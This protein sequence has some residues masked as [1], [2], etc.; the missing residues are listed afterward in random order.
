MKYVSKCFA[1]FF[2]A[3]FASVACSSN[4]AD[5]TA[6]A[7]VSS[8]V[9][10]ATDAP[11]AEDP[12]VKSR[13]FQVKVPTGVQPGQAL[14]LVVL[15]HGYSADASLQD[16]Y[17]KL[18]QAGEAKKFLVALPNGTFDSNGK[19]FW[20]ATDAC[21][22]FGAQVDDV[23]YLTAVINDVKRRFTVDPKRVFLVGHSNGGFMSHRMACERS[24]MIAG[25][26]TLAGVN[27][28]DESK[29]TPT[30]PVSVLHIHGTADATIAYNGGAAVIGAPEFPSAPATVK[31]WAGKNA[32]TATSLSSIGNINL[33]NGIGDETRRES[34][35]GCPAGAAELWTIELG[36]HIP[37][38]DGDYGARIAEWFLAHPKP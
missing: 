23:A 6:D 26:V 1:M 8:I 31:F 9:D 15:L 2:V 12:L 28:K 30:S 33:T 21:C 24:D 29:C 32:C 19:R 10:A 34:Y 22:G 17:F 5:P 14:P 36:S 16:T 18:S 4:A 13:P 35:A 7:P 25:I 11:P 3:C 20:N 37:T 27:W 38:F